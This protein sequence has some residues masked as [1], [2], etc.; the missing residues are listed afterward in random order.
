M[1]PM[2][3]LRNAWGMFGESAASDHSKIDGGISAGPAAGSGTFAPGASTAT[4]VMGGLMGGFGLPMSW[5]GAGFGGMAHGEIMDPNGAYAGGYAGGGAGAGY[6]TFDGV[7]ANGYKTSGAGGVAGVAAPVG[8][9][10]GTPDL[11]AHAGTTFYNARGAS[12][13]EYDNGKGDSGYGVKGS[14]V[15][16]GLMN[17][18]VGFQ[19]GP[20]VD[21]NAH[22]DNAY[23]SKASADLK[24]GND[25]GKY[26]A[27]GGASLQAGAEG[28]KGQVATPF[29]TVGAGADKVTYGPAV[30]AGGSYDSKTGA[31]ELHGTYQD[32]IDAK[33]VSV[34]SHYGAVDTNVSAGEIAYGNAGK[35]YANYDP[36]TGM[37]KA[38]VD[39]GHTG[40]VRVTDAKGDW[41]VG[42]VAS[43][44][45]HAGEIS[46]DIRFS[47]YTEA[48]AD[49][50]KVAASLDGD[51][52]RVKNAGADVTVGSGDYKAQAKGS[53]EEMGTTNSISNAYLEADWKNGALNAGFD[54][55]SYGGWAVKN[56]DASLDGPFGVN[57]KAHL[58]ELTEGLSMKGG[59]LHVDEHGYAATVDRANYAD[60]SIKD[61]AYDANL[62]GLYHA[63]AK[64]GEY[65][66]N[67]TIVNNARAGFTDDEGLYV[68][69]KDATYATQYLQGVEANTAL[70]GDLLQSHLGIGEGAYNS[71]SGK[72]IYASL[73]GP[74]GAKAH[75]EDGK[76]RYLAGKDLEASQS[77]LGGNLGVGVGAKE[78]SFGGVDIGALDFQASLEK[79]HLDAK[80]IGAHGFKS[81]DLHADAN[82]GALAAGAGAKQLNLMD[83]H[84]GEAKLDTAD[85]YTRGA[86]SVKDANVDLVNAKGAHAGLSIGDTKLLGATADFRNG[87]GVDAAKGDWDLSHGRADASFKNAHTGAQLSNA[88][89]DLLGMNVALPDM[90]YNLN[91]SGDA[92]VDL[93]HGAAHAGLSL[94]GTSVNFGGYEMTVPDWV[95]ASAGVD[96]SRGAFNAQL[97]GENGIGA[98]ISLADGNF[99]LNAFGYTLDVDQGIRDVGGAI[100][101]G[102]G[103]VYDQLPSISLPSIS[104][105]SLW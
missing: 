88:S 79:A 19:F 59:K 101:D 100:A 45:A 70:G 5:K 27:D 44:H 3:Y 17:T 87:Y 36:K 81:K 65:G 23:L 13:Y 96:L 73:F 2:A 12:A 41:K 14:A 66:S 22:V 52:F 9:F 90:G 6:A 8:V 64:V 40:G 68:G 42:D 51:G 92:G 16:T 74:D 80:N 50:A 26:Y 25:N 4:D 78:A 11:G 49:H 21:A 63:D 105:P 67:R 99:D 93:S 43:A 83:A 30:T 85:Y 104:L 38:G 69:A 102:A 94:G 77:A 75:I 91:A 29:G 56:A 15:P 57:A 18:D 98:D 72:N 39:D 20:L 24:V 47:G 31:A 60:L 37:F 28:V 32:G 62:G 54:D 48:D 95:A 103:W 71:F 97:G 61:A 53:V 33:N 55:L 1:D 86:A 7:D 10:A 82:I 35:G 46:N 58:G 34:S 89:V 84:V 76:Y